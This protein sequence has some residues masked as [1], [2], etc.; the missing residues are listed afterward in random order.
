[1]KRLTLVVA[2]S[3]LLSSP[4]ASATPLCDLTKQ[5]VATAQIAPMFSKIAKAVN[6]RPAGTIVPPGWLRCSISQYDDSTGAYTCYGPA[7]RSRE[8]D[9]TDLRAISS[10]LRLCYLLPATTRGA[11]DSIGEM[12][13]N[14]A[15]Q[16]GDPT[17][18][19]HSYLESPGT[20]NGGMRLMIEW[21]HPS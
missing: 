7:G 5:I 17:V 11:T 12:Q 4:A 2:M 14:F 16:N 3:A 15:V 6:G 8:A 9:M 10:E 18:T 1:M 21:I 20:A 13:S 19:I